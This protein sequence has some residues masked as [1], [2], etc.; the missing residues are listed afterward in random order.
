MRTAY[1]RA[2]A[3][4]LAS[5]PFLPIDVE[6]S[7]IDE[8]DYRGKATKLAAW[9]ACVLTN[10]DQS[11]GG[12]CTRFVPEGN[13]LFEMLKNETLN[14]VGSVWA[15]TRDDQAI[16]AS[17]GTAPE[18]TDLSSYLN[19]LNRLAT[20]IQNRREQCRVA[21]SASTSP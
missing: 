9:M 13:T 10:V 12:S 5:T 17:S 16:D 21:D 11:H 7:I 18:P 2:S 3:L 14:P 8:A 19:K 4:P 20:K 15:I 1:Y 6:S